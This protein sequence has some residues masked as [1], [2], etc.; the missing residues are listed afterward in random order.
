MSPAL[1]LF[2]AGMLRSKST[3]SLITQIF[4]GVITLSV[5]WVCFGYT[6]TF[7]MSQHGII[8]NLDHAFYIDV[9]YHECSEFA[10][11]I[12]EALFATFQMMFAVITPCQE[13]EDNARPGGVARTV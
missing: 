10:P 13:G 7:G 3:V 12:P 11:D 9:S 4:S 2:E 8:G 1:A 5:M 6:L